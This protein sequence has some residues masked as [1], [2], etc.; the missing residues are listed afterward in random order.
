MIEDIITAA[1]KGGAVVK[2]YFGMILE[3][4]IKS[5]ASDFRTQ[6]DLESEQIVLSILSE[7]F[8][9][10]NIRSE[11]T[12]FIERKSEYTFVVD[13]LD[14]TNNFVLGIPNF[15]VSIGLFKG[16]ECI[17]GVIHAPF[18]NQTYL[19]EQGKGAF[20]NEKK[21]SV[22]KET[23][24]KNSTI[25]Y[26]RGYASSLQFEIDLLEKLGTVN[27]GRYKRYLTN[28]SPAFDYCLLASGK[29]ESIIND[30]NELYDYA[31]GKIIAR[32]AG[33]IITDFSGMHQ[34][35]KKTSRFMASNSQEVHDAILRSLP[36]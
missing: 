16:D 35:D 12:G 19:A 29:I 11:E 2:K 32:E 20:C 34:N 14:G 25:A 10:Y 8:P 4:E 28:W 31:A 7:K 5:S 26:T 17:A 27:T 30:D 23:L 3:L 15:S 9:D 24:L 22:S 6:A 1:E 13:P 18:L 33:A 21:I 36:R